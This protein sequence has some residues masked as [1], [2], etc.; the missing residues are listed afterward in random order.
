MKIS[1]DRDDAHRY[2]KAKLWDD[3][4]SSV[5]H[6]EQGW[7]VKDG[8]TLTDFHS[9]K[10]WPAASGSQCTKRRAESGHVGWLEEVRRIAGSGRVKSF[11][12]SVIRHSPERDASLELFSRS[13]FQKGK[14]ERLFNAPFY[15]PA[16]PNENAKT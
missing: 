5:G 14:G 9:C 13:S 16:L 12:V 8:N 11:S 7:K 1:G 10:W 4:A 6:K 3:S 15:S 2:S